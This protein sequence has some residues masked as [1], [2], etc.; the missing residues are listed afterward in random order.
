MKEIRIVV[1]LTEAN[2]ELVSEFRDMPV[3]ARAERMRVLATLGL[4]ESRQGDNPPAPRYA[5]MYA[6]PPSIQEN[7]QQATSQARSVEEIKA[8]AE[9]DLFLPAA[10]SAEAKLESA[11]PAPAAPEQMAASQENGTGIVA[12]KPSSRLSAFV[13][14]LG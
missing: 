5:L 13:K 7:V 2:P 12:I 10:S 14:S 3:R 4:R 11:L 8:P 1:T 9:P 6:A